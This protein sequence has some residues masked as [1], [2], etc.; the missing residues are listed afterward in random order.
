MADLAESLLI[1]ASLGALVGLFRQWEVQQESP[2]ESEFAGVRTFTLVAMIGAVAAWAGDTHAP[3]AFPVALLALGALVILPRMGRTPENPGGQTTPGAVILTLFTGGLVVWDQRQSAVLVATLTV[4]LLSLK[5]PPP[6]APR[7]FTAADVRS[8]LQFIAITGV[9]LPLVPNRNFGPLG[10]FNPFSMWLMV[11]LISGLG[12]LGYI[13]IRVLGNQAGITLTGLVGGLASSTATTLAFS[14]RSRDDPQRSE[15]YALGIVLACNVM[16]VR[17]GVVAAAIHPPLAW[18]A[19]PQLALMLA[20]GLILTA[21]I[22]LRRRPSSG[23][24]DAPAVSNPLGLRTAI[25]FALLYALVKFMI[26]AAQ[27]AELDAGVLAVSALA[28]LTDV[29]AITVSTSDAARL[30][31]MQNSL[32]ASAI[33]IACVSNTVVKAGLG[34]A[35]GSSPLRLRLTQVLGATALAGIAALAI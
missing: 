18:A 27:T 25:H 9:I 33:T 14:R 22:W 35:L 8:A 13:L 26:K 17:V 20:P 7:R 29:D 12:F 11:V 4:L 21:W 1:S 23:P 3:G 32:A 31:T 24:V 19:T 5:P 16:V 30:G 28:G 2:T 34:A 15:E 10:A 6:R